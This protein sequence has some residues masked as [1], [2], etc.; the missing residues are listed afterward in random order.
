MPKKNITNE[1]LAAMVQR[2]FAETATK[3]DV[4]EV[5]KRM[6]ESEKRLVRHIQGLELNIS[7][8]AS[9]WSQDFERLQDWM[10]ELDA[11]VSVIEGK[12]K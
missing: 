1:E 9:R 10:K 8:Y 2:G 11:R 7:A 3:K 6:G 5:E 12:K 4:Q